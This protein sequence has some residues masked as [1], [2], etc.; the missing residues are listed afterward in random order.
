[1]N[2]LAECLRYA[3]A[4]NRAGFQVSVCKAGF[5]YRVRV[6]GKEIYFEDVLALAKFIT[7]LTKEVEL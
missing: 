5:G 3:L 4:L 6:R 7:N 2:Y 1:M